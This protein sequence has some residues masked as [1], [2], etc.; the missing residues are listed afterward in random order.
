M[1]CIGVDE[2][3]ALD[4]ICNWSGQGFDA[5][6]EVVDHFEM[7][8]TLDLKKTGHQQRL[9]R[10]EKMTIPN[11]LLKL[12][13]KVPENHFLANYD[14]VLNSTISLKDMCEEYKEKLE[15]EKVYKV[16]AKVSGFEKIETLSDIY[17]GM[18]EYAKM[19]DFSGAVFDDK[20]QRWK[21]E[22]SCFSYDVVY[23]LG[24]Q[25]KAANGLSRAT[26]G[27]TSTSKNTLQSQWNT[28]NMVKHRRRKTDMVT[29]KQKD[30]RKYPK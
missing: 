26:C 8:R 13:A 16:L 17:P 5:V 25:N 6:M 27:S 2:C 1:C 11:N 15:V 28:T 7:Y 22:L 10:G 20:I 29:S 14:R 18:F 12:M 23:R 9:A 3:T 24:R 30:N 4:K 21:V 19:K